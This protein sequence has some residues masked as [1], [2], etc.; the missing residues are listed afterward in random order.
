ML[1]PYLLAFHFDLPY[2][3]SINDLLRTGVWLNFPSL[4]ILKKKTLR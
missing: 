2:T 4:N 3:C 1:H